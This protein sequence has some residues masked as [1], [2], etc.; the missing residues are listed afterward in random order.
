M[1]EQLEKE[2]PQKQDPWLTRVFD[3]Y[4]ASTTFIDNNYRRK[5]ED[6]IRHFHSKHASGSKYYTAPYQY[7]QIKTIP[8]KNAFYDAHQ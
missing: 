8:A 2:E 3:A 7:R 6:N 1:G 4:E 5:W